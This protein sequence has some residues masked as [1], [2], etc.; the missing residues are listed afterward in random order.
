MLR[1]VYKAFWHHLHVSLENA[2]L[3]GLRQGGCSPMSKTVVRLHF[4]FSIFLFFFFFASEPV[5]PSSL[6][7]TVELLATFVFVSHDFP[8]VMD[9]RLT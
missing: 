4:A 9:A 3:T 7:S 8:S 1:F 6:N 2:V 5:S